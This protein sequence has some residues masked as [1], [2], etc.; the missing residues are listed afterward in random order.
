MIDAVCAL[1]FVVSTAARGDDWS[2]LEIRLEPVRP[3]FTATETAAV[4]VIIANTGRAP[5]RNLVRSEVA[6]GLLI[7]GPDRRGV[8]VTPRDEDLEAAGAVTLLPGE[9]WSRAFAFDV[10]EELRKEGTSHVTWALRTGDDVK[11]SNEVDLVRFATDKPVATLDTDRGAIVLELWPDRAPNHV[12]NFVRLARSGFYDG[13]TFHRVMR[14]FMIQTG[15][16]KGDGTGGPGYEIPAEF[17]AESF[18]KG[19]LGMARSADPDSAGS[20]FFVMV[21]DNADLNGKYTAFGRVLFGIEAADALSQVPCGPSA[22]GE[23]SRPIETVR[24]R[25]VTV[26]LPPGYDPASNELRKRGR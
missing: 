1:V 25:R 23:M 21:G 7:A 3:A 17:N 22:G 12:L 16:P 24:L 6:R 14:N 5:F 18:V 11:R 10:P 8:R 2:D 4:R 20:Q 9:I 15:C 26:T 19:V 13:L